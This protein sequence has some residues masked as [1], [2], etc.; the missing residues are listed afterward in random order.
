MPN[1][2]N[3]INGQKPEFGNPD[4]I[5]YANRISRAV[6]YYRETGKIKGQVSA[7]EEKIFRIDV[8]A[9]FICV[10]CG[11]E[12]IHERAFEDTSDIPLVGRAGF[13]CCSCN[14]KYTVDLKTHTITKQ[15]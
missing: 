10:E 11:A 1:P 14:Q 15:Q 13:K 7:K 12:N 5:K 2:K 9:K 6:D 3:L 4:H 8:W